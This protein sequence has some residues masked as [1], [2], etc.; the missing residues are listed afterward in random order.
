MISINEF[1]VLIAAVQSAYPRHQ[2]VTNDQAF[3]FWYS[4]LCDIDDAALKNAVRQHILTS[5]FPPSIAEIRQRAHD[6]TAPPDSAGAAEWNKLLRALGHAYS[7]D[8]RETWNSLP[9]VTREIIGGYQSFVNW[10]AI[11]VDKLETV[12]RPMFIKQYEL[13]M[14]QKRQQAATP[15]ALRNPER[16]SLETVQVTEIE[17]PQ[18]LDREKVGAPPELMQALRKRLRGGFDAAV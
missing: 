9:P 8:S 1:K 18:D 4:S 7:P 13:R 14:N 11:P 12:Q 2:V 17:G 15:Q 3:R 16:A 6:L 5:V 10:S